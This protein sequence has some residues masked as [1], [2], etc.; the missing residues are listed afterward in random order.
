[1]GGRFQRKRTYVYLWLIHV[2]VW[3][4]STQY[5][6]Y[7]NIKNKF[8]KIGVVFF[9]SLPNFIYIYIYIYI[10]ERSHALNSFGN[11]KYFLYFHHH[12]FKRQIL[13]KEHCKESKP[14]FFFFFG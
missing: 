14:H 5:C 4:K 1:M 6:N 3:E 7:P 12:L 8:L 2:D 11:A 13:A 9:S 10:N